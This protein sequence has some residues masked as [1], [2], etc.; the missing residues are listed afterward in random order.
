MPLFGACRVAGEV[1][2]EDFGHFFRLTAAF[3]FKR[4]KWRNCRRQALPPR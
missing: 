1:E 2:R 3:K 4:Q